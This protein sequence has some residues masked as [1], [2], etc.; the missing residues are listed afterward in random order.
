MCFGKYFC[1]TAC[2]TQCMKAVRDGHDARGVYYW[3]LNDNF[4]F[5]DVTVRSPRNSFMF[6]IKNKIF[7][8]SKYPKNDWFTID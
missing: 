1:I 8:G 4:E 3:T 7:I 5:A 6:T 2:A